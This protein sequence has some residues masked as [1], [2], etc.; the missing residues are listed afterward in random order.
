M[1][2]ANSYVRTIYALTPEHTNVALLFYAVDVCMHWT[3]KNVNWKAKRTT[4]TTTTKK[5]ERRVNTIRN[6]VFVEYIWKRRRD[7]KNVKSVLYGDTWLG[8]CGFLVKSKNDSDFV[9]CMFI[10]V[11]VATVVIEFYLFASNLFFSCFESH[12]MKKIC[13]V[14][15]FFF[16][17]LFLWIVHIIIALSMK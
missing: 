4:T 5:N 16:A 13:Q 15:D 2:Q 11:V 6:C 3:A 12:H 9:R 17:V 7:R 10:V 1:A 8:I 14:S